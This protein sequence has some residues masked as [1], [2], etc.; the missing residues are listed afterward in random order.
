MP[1]IDD[2]V[3]RDLYPFKSAGS[4]RLPGAFTMWTEGAATTIVFCHGSPTWSFMF[5]KVMASLRN[6]YRCIAAD[7]LGFGLLGAPRHV[8]LHR[9]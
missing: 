1:M 5:R 3:D 9:S 7:L 2:H 4:R 8:R 6:D